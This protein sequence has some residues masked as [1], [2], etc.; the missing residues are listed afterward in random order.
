MR[1]ADKPAARVLSDFEHLE[2]LRSDPL[3][4]QKTAE[5]TDCLLLFCADLQPYLILYMCVYAVR[6]GRCGARLGLSASAHFWYKSGKI[7]E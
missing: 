5:N 4:K 3:Q 7:R 1:R 6:V 2:I